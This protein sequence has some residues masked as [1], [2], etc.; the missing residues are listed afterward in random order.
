MCYELP[1]TLFI[2]QTTMFSIYVIKSKS[3]NKIYIGFTTRDVYLRLEDHNQGKTIS[4]KDYR[5]WGLIYFESYRSEK[6][7]RKREKMLK[8][9][10]NSLTHLKNRIDNSLKSK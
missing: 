5:P 10:G 4:T 7:A 8:H 2:L 6:D 1:R 3:Y 9:Y